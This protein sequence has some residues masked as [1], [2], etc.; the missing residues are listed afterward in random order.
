MANLLVIAPQNQRKFSLGLS[1][2]IA[3][4]AKDLNLEF[5]LIETHKKGWTQIPK[6]MTA[7]SQCQCVVFV[8]LLQSNILLT[9]LTFLSSKPAI[10]IAFGGDLYNKNYSRLIFNRLV[11]KINIAIVSN[12]H[13]GQFVMQKF[14]IK[15]TKV[16]LIPV[17]HSNGHPL[18]SYFNPKK[19][20]PEGKNEALHIF[21]GNNGYRSQ[22]HQ[23]I[24][25]VLA[26]STSIS[27]IGITC[28]YGDWVYINAIEDQ[29]R[30]NNR[31]IFYKDFMKSED[32]IKHLDS[33]D[34]AIFNNERQQGI[35]TI[36]ILLALG[37]TIYICQENGAINLLNENS[38]HY[39][40]VSDI[41]KSEKIKTI[42]GRKKTENKEK[43]ILYMN[44]E[45]FSR[46]FK[47][48]LLS[49]I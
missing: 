45:I 9:V 13:E 25:N 16:I 10:W 17:Y 20:I 42:S 26:E 29:Y 41:L 24:L 44:D 46:E 27:R 15:E 38:I 21:L 18:I 4:A 31:V 2:T 32:Y 7:Y 8:S 28:S 36:L 22:R 49:L 6:I 23:E 35:Q 1:R 40:E 14:E 43:A 5:E 37:K 19:N 39:F 30:A 12:E 3:K 34:I 48:T 47:D 33:Y 11:K